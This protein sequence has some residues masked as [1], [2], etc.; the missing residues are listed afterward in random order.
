MTR[1]DGDEPEPE[2][3]AGSESETDGADTSS[4]ERQLSLPQALRHELK[5]PM[6]PI[7][8]DARVL[9]ESI[10]GPLITVGDVVTYHVLEAGREPDVALVDGQ[11]KREAV[12]DEIERAVTA[13]PAATITVTNPPAVLTESLL[14][15][16]VTA[17]ERAEPTTIFVEGEEDLAVLPALLAAPDGA[18]V[19][20]GQP[21]EGMV[22]VHVDESARARAR[23]LLERF[24]G[25][26]AVLTHVIERNG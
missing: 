12:D 6:G 24:E 2:P 15:A 10:D 14:E 7:E 23:A 13:D 20:Y 16:L 25:D 9:L 5:D 11:T 8:T 21:D 22:H 26:A 3:D 17:L 18:H 19:V 4:S 1:D